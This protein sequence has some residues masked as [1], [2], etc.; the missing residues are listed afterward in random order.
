MSLSGTHSL[1]IE[2]GCEELPANGLA[3]LANAFAGGLEAALKKRGVPYLGAQALWTP[4]RLALQVSGLPATLA[5]Q[6]SEKRGPALS[7][8]LDASGQPSKALLGFAASCGVDVA[9]LERLETDKGSWFVHRASIA[10]RSITQV[11][12]ELLTEALAG[13]AIAKPMR[14]GDENYAFLRPVHWLVCLLDDVVVPCSVFGLDSGRI[15]YGHRFHAPE[16]IVLAHA[17]D[18][19]ANLLTAFVQIDPAQRAHAVR[20]G[21]QALAA[22]IHGVAQMRDALVDEVVNLT[23][24]PVPI[25]CAIPQEFMRL[26]EATIVTTIEVHQRYFPI[27]ATDS[28]AARLLPAFVGVANIASVDESQ[29]RRGYERVVRPRLADADFFYQQDLKTPLISHQEGLKSLVFQVKLGS[30]WDKSMRVAALAAHLAP[31]FGLDAATAAHAAGLAK[32]DLLS[33][34]VGEFPE[35]QGEMGKTYASAQGESAA[36]A[37]S[38]DEVYAPRAGAS[39][40]ASSALGRLLAVCERLDTLAGIFAV[41]LKPTGSKDAFG[42]RRAA[43]GLARTL[44]ESA[45]P[46]DLPNAL[47]FAVRQLPPLPELA[48]EAAKIALIEAL[49]A[50]VVERL[51]AYYAER[52]M[53]VAVIDAVVERKPVDL[54]DFDLRLRGCQAFSALPECAALGAANKRIRNILRKLEA[55][56]PTVI[57]PALFEHAAEIALDSAVSAAQAETAPLFAAQR[58]VEGLSRLAQLRAPIDLY[59]DGVMVMAEDPA[60]RNNRLASLNRVS[61]LFLNVADVSV[62][63]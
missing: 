35:L 43:L 21:V 13:L 55:A 19:A 26:P 24:W 42:L 8:G 63:G 50:F 14:W 53:A 22:E 57:D 48:S 44:I 2:L 3:E 27:V 58:Y 41:G 12:P 46:L 11:I 6:Q 59:F 34:M 9:A 1:L 7:A 15:T 25:R 40:I 56:A 33:R 39:A 20:T 38:L 4:R 37:L 30:V 51:R 18:Y 10:G 28:A 60:V 23:E 31:A 45:T 52:G 49:Y 5:A 47:E 32:C 62:L 36:V 54:L 16:A 29:I 17:G 61:E